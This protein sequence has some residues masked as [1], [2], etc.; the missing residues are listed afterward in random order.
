MHWPWENKKPVHDPTRNYDIYTIHNNDFWTYPTLPLF[1]FPDNF[2]CQILSVR[3]I[4]EAVA[5]LRGVGSTLYLTILSNNRSII[6]LDSTVKIVSS[7]TNYLHWALTG[8]VS[9]FAA[10]KQPITF[11]LPDLLY[12]FPNDILLIDTSD[13]LAGDVLRELSIRIKRWEFY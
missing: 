2:W 12:A 7:V 11:P 3:I 1:F 4:I 9:P 10:P 6:R 13:L 5:G 8:T